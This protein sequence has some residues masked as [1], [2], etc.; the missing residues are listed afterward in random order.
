MTLSKT[1]IGILILIIFVLVL[2]TL[3]DF[4]T[5]TLSVIGDAL[6]IQDTLAPVDV[7][8][9]IAGDD[10]RTLYAIQLYRLGY[11]KLLFFTGGWCLRH[12]YYHG[13]HALQLALEAGVP[14]DAVAYDDSQEFSTYDEALLLQKYLAEN[15]PAFHSIMV[16]SDGFHMHRA[17]MTYRYVFGQEFSVVMAPVPFDQTPFKQQW[18]TDRAS[19][20]YVIEEYAKLLYSF[21]RFQLHMEWLSVLEKFR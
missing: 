7:I 6:V 17:Q 16:V 5:Q 21:F 12:S 14:R 11:A 13:A 19:A 4:P 1:S 3:I 15:Q 10:Y 20:K 9:V 8:H 18:W 2:S